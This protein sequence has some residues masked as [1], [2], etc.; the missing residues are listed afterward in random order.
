MD[1]SQHNMQ[2]IRRTNQRGGRCLSV[3][4][5][6]DANTI[7]DEAASFCWLMI[8][9]GASFI[10]GAVPGGA[11][12]TTLM[13]SLLA[14]LP[15]GE[16]IVTAQNHRVLEKVRQKSHSQD[17]CLLA[18]EIGEGP[19]FAYIWGETAEDFFNMNGAGYRPVTCLHADTPEQTSDI[20]TS[21]GVSES[22]INDLHLHLYI[23]NF[24]T[25]KRKHRV[26]NIYYRIDQELVPLYSWDETQDRLMR[27]AQKSKIIQHVSADSSL[28]HEQMNRSWEQYEDALREMRSNDTYEFE[29]VRKEVLDIYGTDSF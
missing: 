28:T 5:L 1:T 23:R 14:F 27:S 10:T 15:P 18:H 12:K 3:I 4:D 21:C 9:H 20:L 13:A 8:Q 7:S 6:I 26:T 24:G 16:K 29:A 11:G 22:D 2:E 17:I 25:T 19:W